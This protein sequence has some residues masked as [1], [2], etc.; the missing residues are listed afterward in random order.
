MI[1]CSVIIPTANRA[2]NLYFTLQSI[3]RLKDLG[4]AEIIVIDNGSTDNTVNVCR[5]FEKLIPNFIYH[6]DAIPGL[7]TGRHKGAEIAK[8]NILSFLDDDVE[9]TPDWLS[10]IVETFS[11]YHDV[12]LVTGPC[13]PK[14]EVYPP[15]WVDYFFT[16]APYGGKMCTWLSLLDLGS[17]EMVVDPIYVWG[18]NFSI[19]KNTLIELG[20]FHP[21]C[22]P[23]NLQHYQGDGETGLSYKATM[24][25]YKAFYSPSV[26]LYHQVSK[27]RL[28]IEYFEK[29]A[30]YQGVCGSFTKIRNDNNLYS[31]VIEQE[32]S[33]P[34]VKN[35]YFNR[36]FQK[37]KNKL[38]PSIIEEEPADIQKLRRQFDLK[39]IEGYNFH[40]HAYQ[41]NEAVR[42]WVLRDN[43][44]DYKLPG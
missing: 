7:L 9:V 22:I 44:W 4:Q 27:E 30:F 15:E 10:G 20:G 31:G 38:K 21:D 24:L 11:K 28:T 19:R 17:K 32:K 25:G 6:Y 37:I 34:E 1:N 41:S 5:Q 33:N 16:Q 42:E 18:L 43:Y 35:Q 14:Y 23:P 39:L 13:L 36:V 26:M 12:H 29:R 8:T 3:S 2:S 40:Q